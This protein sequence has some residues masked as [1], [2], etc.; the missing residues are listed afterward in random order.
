MCVFIIVEG[1]RRGYIVILVS[2]DAQINGGVAVFLD[3][4]QQGGAIAVPDFPR[5]EVVLGVQQLPGH[6]RNKM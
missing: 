5:M 1:Y 3:G 6:K 2:N 4:G